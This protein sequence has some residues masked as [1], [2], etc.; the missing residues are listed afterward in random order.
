MLL[1]IK[2]VLLTMWHGIICIAICALA[3][4]IGWFLSTA[5]PKDVAVL[6]AI[7]IA[8]M[9]ALVFAA[10]LI[11]AFVT[12]VRDNH[13]HLLHKAWLEESARGGEKL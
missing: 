10:L 13:E 9:V 8:A 4:I 5:V 1:W 3:A 12:D 7:A 6:V 11:W 2:A